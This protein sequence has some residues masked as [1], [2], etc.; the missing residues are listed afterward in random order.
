MEERVARPSKRN[1]ASNIAL[2]TDGIPPKPLKLV[3][4]VPLI[5]VVE[6]AAFPKRGV[7]QQVEEPVEFA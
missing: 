5:W 2:S 3:R 6:L 1:K 7:D 4:S